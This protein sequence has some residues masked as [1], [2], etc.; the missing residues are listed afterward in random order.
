MADNL[1]SVDV[2]SFDGELNKDVKDFHSK[3]NAWNHARNATTNSKVGDLYSIQNEPANKLCIQAPYVIIGFIYLYEDNWLVYST[4]D[5]DSEIGLFKETICSYQKLVN[6]RC[7]NFNRLNLVT[8]IA[9]ENFD[10]TWSAYWADGHRNPDRTLNINNIPWV[11]TCSLDGNGCKVCV[12]VQPLQLDCDKIRLAKPTSYPCVRVVKSNAG[13]SLLNG[14]YLAT[15]AYSINGQKVTDYFGISNAQAIFSHENAGGSIDILVSDLDQDYDEFELV[16]I[17]VVNQQT[18]AK[19]AGIYST[20]QT[21]VSFDIIDNSLVSVPLEFIPLRNPIIESSENISELSNSLLRIKPRNKF[22]FNYQPLANQIVTKWVSVEFPAEYY[23]NGG[24]NMSAMRDE[25]YALNIEWIYDDGDV[26]SSYHIPNNAPFNANFLNQNT[27][28]VTSLAQSAVD[29]GVQIAEGL[30]G[31]WESTELYPDNKPAIWGNLCGKPIRHHKMPEQATHPSVVHYVNN[32]TGISGPAIRVLGFKFE[33]IQRPLDN[34][35][36]PIMN[37]V[38]YRILRG[39]REGNKTVIAKGLVNNLINY[40]LKDGSG[41]TGLFPNYPYNAGGVDPYLSDT[42]TSTNPVT[43]NLQGVTPIAGSVF[44]VQ[45]FHSPDTQFKRPFLSPDNLKLYC[46]AQGDVTGSFDYPE[47]HPKYKL[48]TNALFVVGLV[49][50]IGYSIIKL[51]GTRRTKYISPSIDF[52]DSITGVIAGASSGTVLGGMASPITVPLFGVAATAMGISGA[53]FSTAVNIPTGQNNIASLTSILTGGATPNPYWAALAGA[54]TAG[55]VPGLSNKFEIEQI[56][57]LLG[58][59]PSLVAVTQ[60]LPLFTSYTNEGYDTIIRFIKNANGFR[61]AALQYR[62]HGFYDNYNTTSLGVPVNNPIQ[63]SNY[64]GSGFQDFGNTYK[65]NNLYR[66]KSVITRTATNIPPHPS[67][68]TKFTIATSPA[69]IDYKNPTDTVV[70]SHAA[71]YYG[72]LKL[73][74]RNQYGQIGAV[75]QIPVGCVNKVQIVAGSQPAFT[76]PVIF[77][78]DTYISRYAE[79]NTMFFFYD[80]LY[81]Q[82]DDYEY[83]YL[84]Y[85]M[86]PYPKYWVNSDT[87]ELA[88]FFQSILPNLMSFSLPNLPTGKRALDN[89]GY[90]NIANHG[91]FLIKNAY[92]YLF[93][94]GVR[95]FYVESEIN[96]FYRDWEDGDDKRFYDNEKYSDIKTMFRVPN[97]KNLDYYKYDYS[98][99]GG[100]TF[101]NFASWAAVQPLYYD[102]IK[103]E[104]CYVNHNR[105]VQYSLP[106]TSELIRDNWR[107]FPVNNYRDFRSEVT[108]VKPLGLT[109]ALVMFKSESPIQIQG[110]ENLELGSGT[111]ITIGTGSLLSQASQNL[112]NAERPYEYGSCQN[113]RSIINTPAGVFWISQNQ[114]KIFTIREGML[115]IAMKDMNWWFAEYLPYQI[116]KNFPNF[117]VLDNPVVGV[118]CQSI[119][120]NENMLLY[121]MKRDFRVRKDIEVNIKYV[122]GLTF[123]VNEML[124]VQLGDPDYFEDCS[125]TISYDPKRNT[126]VSHHDWHPNLVVP[127]KNTFMTTKGNGAWE[128]N[129]RCDLYCN[130]YGVDYPFEIEFLHDA[131]QNVNVLNSVEYRLEVYKF[132]QNCH[133]R[134]LLLKENFDEAVVSNNEQVSGLLRLN[135]TPVND[136]QAIVTYPI[137]NPASVDILYSKVENKYRF[138]QFFDLTDDRGEF[139]TAQ[140]MLWLT[141]GNGYVKALNP[142]NLDYAKDP[143]QRKRFRSYV[144]NVFLRKTV[145]SY[146][147]IIM[148]LISSKETTS[149]R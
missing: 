21:K 20:R 7:L 2:H 47:N 35:G 118:G 81:G 13:G 5:V 67:D 115:N 132:A 30:M 61:H 34:S 95:D 113:L 51:N 96:T 128:H 87:F 57:G 28:S 45:T 10:C 91:F 141:A 143:L 37:I 1:N 60:G 80:W 106:Q 32:G 102:P 43:G 49:G 66:S 89:S 38:G 105:R 71:S 74:L 63:D 36:N 130:F 40:D 25:N 33:N 79:R 100:R 147:K 120:D 53:A 62:S 65:V 69:S 138:N 75:K 108:G 98:L 92:F 93:N 31:Y 124:E 103:A 107:I 85:K 50:G 137:F 129:V 3:P 29:G 64:L 56:P 110:V 111:V 94:S 9:K 126:W 54:V 131:A 139:S 15:I 44:N 99:S 140:R 82:P 136:P 78:G 146:K 26:S 14:S 133:D 41:K 12:P 22:D 114:G 11:E 46:L 19:K 101:V 135:P 70:N 16:V 39:S 77:G 24:N 109:G 122:S 97:I 23:K 121:F 142:V 68:N 119:Y 145:S 8:G 18:V 6:D 144:Q 48:I 55:Y 127:T 134:Y 27:A 73:N 52:I 123:L 76:S 83:D 125:W 72:A 59:M 4:N 117:S 17:S 86:L 90:G 104:T 116:L 88:E 112:S 148:S 58:D 84:S 42:E 149:I